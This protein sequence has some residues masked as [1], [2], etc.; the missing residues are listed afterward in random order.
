M[1]TFSTKVRKFL[2]NIIRK[3]FLKKKNKALKLLKFYL[4]RHF[5]KNIN[6]KNLA[7]IR[8]ML[9]IKINS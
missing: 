2:I 4:R 3:V 6:Y 1:L 7:K 5:N 9:A 8:Q